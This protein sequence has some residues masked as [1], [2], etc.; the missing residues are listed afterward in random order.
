MILNNTILN[1]TSLPVAV[2]SLD[3]ASLRTK[4]IANNLA[5]VSTPGYRRIEVAFEDQ[6]K[7]AL[8]QDNLQGSRT[9]SN[10]MRSGR[11]EVLSVKPIA[12]RSDDPTLPGEINSVDIDLEGAKLAEAQIQY[13]FAVRFIRDRFESITEAYRA[14]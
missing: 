14:R 9:H 13:N 10:H 2:K 12:Y 8:D 6:L 4:A 5:N 1:H 11:P 7:K 3:A